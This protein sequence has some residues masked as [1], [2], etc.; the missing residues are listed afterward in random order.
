MKKNTTTVQDPA[1]ALKSVW[2]ARGVEYD[3]EKDAARAMA[4][5]HLSEFF[6]R[7]DYTFYEEIADA[8]LEHVDEV[9]KV[10]SYMEKFS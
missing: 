4:F 9:K 2:K 3:K 5:G 10:V 7:K 1:H 6:Q 8:V